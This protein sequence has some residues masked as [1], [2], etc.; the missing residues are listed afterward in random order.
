MQAKRLGKLFDPLDHSSIEGSVGYA[1]SPQVLVLGN[2][3]RIYFS[4]RV[5]DTSGKFVSHV[6]Y[7][8]MSKDLKHTLGISQHEVISQGELGCFDEHGIFPFHVCAID[9]LVYAYTNGWSRRAS[10]SVETGIGLAVSHDNGKTFIRSGPGPIVTALLHE[11]FL[12][13][14]A[15]VRRFQSTFHM[16]YI[17]GKEWKSL[18]A[19]ST[20]ERIYK[21][22]HATSEDGIGWNTGRG[23]QLI[24]DVLGPD[25]SQ[26][27]PSVIKHNGKYHMFFCFR[28]SFDFRTGRGRGYRL[29]YATSN[30]LIDWQ[31]QDDELEFTEPFDDWDNEMQCYPHVFA[32]DQRIFLL[33]N[34]NEFGRRGFGA[35]ELTF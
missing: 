6:A 23:E 31:R 2:C 19:D 17:F 18:S 33:Y 16:W 11:R 1:Q 21:I 35:L 34:G 28:E 15:F 8:D 24:P 9:D 14:D 3:V 27:L 13:G 20:P 22:A 32:S 12:V 26:A 5:V 29:G 10:V 4:T 7:V 25:E 30:D